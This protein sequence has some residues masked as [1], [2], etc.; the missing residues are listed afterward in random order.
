[1]VLNRAVNAHKV[2][3]CGIQALIAAVDPFHDKPLANHR[4]WPDGETS[5]SVV[6][7]WKQSTTI[8][9]QGDGASVLVYTWPILNASDLH[10]CARRNAV[11]D[12]IT[13]N[14]STDVT[15]APVLIKSYTAAEAAAPSLPFASATADSLHFVPDEY[16]EDGPCRLVG[17]G[18]EV[19]DV[20]A[21]IY[22]QGTCTVFEVPQTTA[23]KE[24]VTVRAQ[25]I[26]GVNYIQT[27]V[28][29]T[30]MQRYP[31]NLDTMMMYPSTQQWDAKEGAYIVIPF[32]SHENSCQLAQYRTPFVN[33][34]PSSPMDGTGLNT[35]ARYIGP[36]AGGSPSG[37]NFVFLANQYAPVHSRGIYLT[38]L[39]A[40][41][42]FTITTS[43]WLESFPV[44]TSPILSLAKECCEFDPRALAM[45][46]SIMRQMPVG[47]MVK[48][49]P[50]GE[51]F[52]EAVETALPVLGT[53][54][55]ALF[56]EFSPLIGSAAAAGTQYAKEARQNAKVKRKKAK[57]KAAT[58]NEVKQL[59]KQDVAR[60]LATR[61]R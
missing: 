57:A 9:S 60:E 53:A 10:F 58:K 7:H 35:T 14:V 1:M 25:T 54:A 13:P 2:S 55:S 59:V 22:K 46:S 12:T 47:C 41:S 50:L 5:R 33:A 18:V 11:V 21:E 40:N 34:T 29:V 56:P 31:S 24:L 16:F 48:E 20:T 39:N 23:D 49:N 43:F 19:R 32:S 52:W 4:G 15:I 42:A 27:P 3:E 28:E 17:M 44:Q 45:I 38:G 26:A 51:W 37:D 30:R 8:K 61:K 6:R 36:Y